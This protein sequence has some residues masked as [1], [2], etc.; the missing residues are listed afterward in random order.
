[1]PSQPTYY[2]VML[3]AKDELLPNPEGDYSG[4]MSGAEPT[5]HTDSF[6]FA[7]SLAEAILAPWRL[8]LNDRFGGDP[9]NGAVECLI[10]EIRP[11]SLVTSA[12][13]ARLVKRIGL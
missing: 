9:N 10:F 5:Y 11:S 8:L 2:T 6:G 13:Q 3:V 7:C 12:C 1:M 4:D